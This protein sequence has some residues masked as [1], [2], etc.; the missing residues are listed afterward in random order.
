MTSGGA[1]WTAGYNNYGQLGDGE[2]SSRRYFKMVI[3]FGVEAMAAGL[4]H[5]VVIKRSGNVFAT[6]WNKYGQLGTGSKTT[7]NVFV[8]VATTDVV[9]QYGY[10]RNL[11]SPHV[12]AMTKASV[13]G[14]FI[15]CIFISLAVSLL[16]HIACICHFGN[17]MTSCLSSQFFGCNLICSSILAFLCDSL[18]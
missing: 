5:S 4:Y 7:T 16:V 10:N 3:S 9:S 13:P 6:G 8:K 1:L 14:V 11:M 18:V 12:V 2:T 15:L 17:L